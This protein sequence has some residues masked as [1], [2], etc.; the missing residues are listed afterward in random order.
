MWPQIGK[1]IAEV[2]DHGQLGFVHGFGVRTHRLFPTGV[3]R[4][5]F[6]HTGGR[7]AGEQ[8]RPEVTVLDRRQILL[9]ALVVET[10]CACEHRRH[11]NAPLVEEIDVVGRRVADRERGL[12]ARFAVFDEIDVRIHYV[13]IA[14]ERRKLTI[15]FFGHPPIVGVEKADHVAGS[16]VEASVPRR[17]EPPWFLEGVLEPLDPGG[18]VAEPLDARAIDDDDLDVV[19]GLGCDRRQR[20]ADVLAVVVGRHDN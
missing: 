7:V 20:V 15:E 14:I 19:V 17:A 3:V 1:P 4:E 9:E 2:V 8:P 18:E 10:R 16:E 6:G 13:C 12:A 11:R 5:R